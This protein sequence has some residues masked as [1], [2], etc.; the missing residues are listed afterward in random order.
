MKIKKMWWAMVMVLL[1]ATVTPLQAGK[2][3]STEVAAP[4]VSLKNGDPPP[5]NA[6]ALTIPQARAILK[7]AITKRYV[8]TAKARVAKGR[9]TFDL[10]AATDVRVTTTGFGFA[11]TVTVDG[12]SNPI[13]KYVRFK[14]L[15][16]YIQAFQLANVSCAEANCYNAGFLPNP[17]R[18][19]LSWL[20]LW[21]DE[22]AAQNF[23][24]ANN[25]LIYAA[26]RNEGDLEFSAAAKAWREN[27]AKP[28]LSP[29]ADRHRILAL[30][31]VQEMNFDSAIEHYES[32]LEVQPAWPAGWFDV[33]L[34]GAQHEDYA[35]AV[36]CMNHY[37]ELVPDAPDAHDVRA[38]MVIWEDKAK[39]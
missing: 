29:A 12:I 10:S 7:E 11:A 20:C 31:A 39:H 9:D 13:K 8:G 14:D 15:P 6:L 1:I 22:S 38:Q 18:D 36:D 27:P 37:L 24:D 2:D 30:N 5:G 28:P 26:S 35:Y 23:V 25:R 21:S 3:K 19:H 32:A 4:P 34:I 16:E 17:D 33:A